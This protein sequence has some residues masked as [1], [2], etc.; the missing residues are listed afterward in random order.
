VV[1]LAAIDAPL[2]APP[3]ALRAGDLDGE[4]AGDDVL[5]LLPGAPGLRLQVVMDDLI[6]GAPLTGLSERLPVGTGARAT[7]RL[8]IDDTNGDGEGDIVVLADDG[9]VV[10]AGA[11]LPAD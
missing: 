9:L 3:L 6:A 4:A 2:A 7:G 1:P 10:Y 5:A 11:A 8:V